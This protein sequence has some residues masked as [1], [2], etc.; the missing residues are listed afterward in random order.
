MNNAVLLDGP[1]GFAVRGWSTRTFPIPPGT[2]RKGENTLTIEDLEPTPR[3]WFLVS[4]VQ[5]LVPG[6]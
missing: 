4:D 2:L 6:R 3:S 5:I 1:N